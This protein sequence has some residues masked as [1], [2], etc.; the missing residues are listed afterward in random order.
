MTRPQ[1]NLR[2][3]WLTTFAA[4][5]STACAAY[6][7]LLRA[8]ADSRVPQPLPQTEIIAEWRQYGQ[9]GNRIGPANAPVTIVYFFDFQCPYC[10]RQAPVLRTIMREY[11]GKVAVVYRHLPSA[12][13]ELSQ[14]AA[15]ASECAARAGSFAPYHDLLV[16]Q[17]SLGTK[18]WT[19]L[20]QDAGIPD[21]TRFSTCLEGSAV[22]SL[23]DRD[24]AAATELGVLVTPTLLVNEVMVSGYT[25]GDVLGRL[26]EAALWAGDR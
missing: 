5:V 26:V 14:S 6:V 11:P 10:V 17:D 2:R 4:I 1:R 23:I 21:M 18:T 12:V 20:A 22:S 8:T 9:E 15:I 7:V 16:E 24:I 13:S 19:S 3:E 25:D